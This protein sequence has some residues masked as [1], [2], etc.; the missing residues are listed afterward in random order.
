MSYTC[1][2]LS[3]SELQTLIDDGELKRL[4]DDS[5]EKIEAG[6]YSVYNADSDISEEDK[7]QHWTGL[8]MAFANENVLDQDTY[9]YYCLAVYKDNVLCL[10][11]ANYFDSA[12]NSYNYCHALLSLI[13]NSKS[14]AFTEEFWTPQNTIMRSVGADKMVFYSTQGGTMSFR[15]KTA[16]GIPSLFDYEN[17]V[18]T[19]EEEV[20]DIDSK[21]IEVAPTEDG[22][23][24]SSEVVKLLQQSTTTVKTVRPLK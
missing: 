21:D 15:A 5:K 2:H 20:Y 6:N 16:Q 13:N 24:K 3:P 22:S 11:S 14:Y 18:Q 1:K 17:H 9:S 10:L 7:L 23:T 19:E 8:M 12:D 4:Y